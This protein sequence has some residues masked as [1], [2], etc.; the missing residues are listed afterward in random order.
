[1]P[2]AYYANRF[3]LMLSCG[4]SLLAPITSEAGWFFEPSTFHECMKEEI[5]SVDDGKAEKYGRNYCFD[6]F[7]RNKR[8]VVQ[9]DNEKVRFQCEQLERLYD[10]AKSKWKQKNCSQ[11]SRTTRCSYDCNSQYLSETG[12]SCCYCVQQTKE[13]RRT[14]SDRDNLRCSY[15]A[16]E[17]FIYDDK[18]CPGAQ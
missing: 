5:K 4:F 16:D 10:E 1:M 13:L 17:V 6:K 15:L 11:W 7:C 8:R 3:A 14:E 2:Y 12:S 9:I 18:T